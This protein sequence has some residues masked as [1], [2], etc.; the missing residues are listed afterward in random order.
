MKKSENKSF[1]LILVLL[2]VVAVVSIIWLIVSII[3]SEEKYLPSENITVVSNMTES[4]G[5]WEKVEKITIDSIGIAVDSYSFDGGINWQK[6]NEYY[7]TEKETLIIVVKDINGKQTEP[8]TYETMNIDSVPPVISVNLPSEVL[9]NSKI[10]LGEFVSVTDDN[11][12]VDGTITMSP[13]S[14]DTSKEGKKTITFS[15][16]DKAGNESSID[17]T[18]E[19]V[20][21]ISNQTSKV[22]Y[23]YRVKNITEYECKTYDCSYYEEGLANV[24]AMKTT[25]CYSGYNKKLTFNNGCYIVPAGVDVSCTQAITTVDRY[26]EYKADDGWTYVID[27]IALDTNGKQINYDGSGSLTGSANGEVYYQSQSS[28]STSGGVSNDAI[29]GYD[30]LQNMLKTKYKAEPCGKYE[31]AINGF[32][33]AICSGTKEASC[34]DGYSLIDGKCKKR[35]EKKCSDTCS[36]YTWSEWSEWSETIVT[37]SETIQVETKVVE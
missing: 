22:Y 13:S 19:I 29:D 15:A 28:V 33:H 31:I 27:I 5:E 17:V 30:A 2:G 7:A 20:K 21:S 32:C 34:E 4:K 1:N 26:S 11:S 14:L 12:G 25:K 18:I 9:L 37:P 6:S 35:V 3:L 24:S 36:K 8:V 16:K 10:N 23:R